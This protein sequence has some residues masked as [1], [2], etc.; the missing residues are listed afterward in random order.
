MEASNIGQVTLVPSQSLRAFVLM[1]HTLAVLAVNRVWADLGIVSVYLMLVIAVSAGCCLR[2]LF[3]PGKLN[4][5]KIVF[6]STEQC[7]VI[8]PDGIHAKSL[9]CDFRSEYL[10][11]IRL[12]DLNT[13]IRI[14][15]L[16]DVC[17]EAEWKLLQRQI[18]LIDGDLLASGD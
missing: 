4:P 6:D 16:R 9:H 7:Y 12:L 14:V 11:V 8:S 10:L 13:S 15:L 3:W 2:R 17:N 18:R 1:F 5:K